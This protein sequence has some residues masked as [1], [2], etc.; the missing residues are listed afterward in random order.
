MEKGVYVVIVL[1][2]ASFLLS[3]YFYPQMPERM[4]SHWGIHG[5]ANGSIGRFWGS[6][7]GP[8]VITILSLL[9]IVIPKI[10]PLK[11]NIKEF[12]KYFDVFVALLLLFMLA[13]QALMILWNLGIQ[14]PIV[15]FISVWIAVLFF[16]VGLLCEHAKKNWFI[17][18]RSPWTMSSEAVW[19]KANKLAGKLFKICGIIALLGIVVPPEWAFVL[20]LVPI[21]ASAFYTTYYSYREYQKEEIKKGRE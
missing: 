3:I 19:D 12:R 6:F 18:I 5:E 11:E 8:F 2:A 10:D 20:I 9:F 4:V 21:I 17:G 13:L 1:V 14:I 16:F 7:I 15:P